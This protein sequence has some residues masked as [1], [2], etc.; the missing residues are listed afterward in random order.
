MST[1]V[2][3]RASAPDPA[4]AN[5]AVNQTRPVAREP[6]DFASFELPKKP[7]VTIE[8]RKSWSV[9]NAREL[10]GYRE[11]LYF[12]AWRDLKVRYKQT[13]LGIGW[14]VIQPLLM[15]LVFSVILGRVARIQTGEVPYPLVVFSGLIPWTFFSA[16]I[17]ICSVSLISNSH[18][19][20]KVY[21]P[22]VLLP[23][24]ALAGRLIDF[25]VSLVILAALILFYRQVLHYH[26]PLT[27][28]IIALPFVI[29]LMIILT[30]ALGMLASALN[31][32]YRDI[33]L[34][35]PV[36]IQLWMFVSPVLYPASA[37]SGNAQRLYFLNPLSGLIDGF[38]VSLFGGSFN[39]FGLGV[40]L[41][42]TICLFVGSAW[43]FRRTQSLFAD[44]I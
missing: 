2:S 25:A 40:S 13:F 9:L 30:F 28:N 33:G 8:A 38:R 42:F 4:S 5:T 29:V 19:I 14:V 41:M 16:A 17:S 39:R 37:I 15:T 1:A 12:L 27:R 35:L 7:L 3:N 11:L 6:L 24:A 44:V 22:R 32:K 20:T 43:I 36:L 34:I 26:L 21:F 23:A 31:V 10:W 18:L